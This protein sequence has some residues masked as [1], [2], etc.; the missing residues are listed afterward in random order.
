MSDAQPQPESEAAA[1]PPPAPE[2]PAST[3]E[4]PASGVPPTAPPAPTGG[5]WTRP[6]WAGPRLLYSGLIHAG[7][8]LGAGL[9]IS[10]VVAVLVAVA[11]AA[12]AFSS[13]G[14][15]YSGLVGGSDSG[16]DASA[17]S[18]SSVAFNPLSVF[19]GLFLI[20]GMSLWGHV[21]AKFT[22]D[23]S[24]VH[25]EAHGGV[26][27]VP[28]VVTVALLAA[29]VVWGWL[30][31]RRRPS[32][33]APAR[34][35][36]ALITGAAYAIVLT[37][38]SLAC[39]FYLKVDPVALW[40]TTAGWRLLLGAFVLGTVSAWLGREFA[41][42]GPGGGF[43]AAGRAWLGGVHPL[44]REVTAVAA[45]GTVLFGLAVLVATA[46][47]GA[48]VGY[49]TLL[50]TLPLWF[51][52]AVVFAASLGQLGGI[53]GSS[54][55]SHAET[56]SVFNPGDFA[57]WLW[58]TIV[59][60]VIAA[61]I[62][63]VR[64]GLERPAESRRELRSAWLLPTAIAVL[65][66]ALPWVF[67]APGVS[68]TGIP[69]IGDLHAGVTVAW[70][71]FLTSLVFGA[72]T[73]ATARFAVPVLQASAPRLVAVVGAGRTTAAGGVVPLSRVGRRVVA[74]SA[75]GLGVLCVLAMVGSLV[76]TGVANTLYSPKVVAERY[77][78]D[79]AA[80]HVDA[81][82]A[83]DAGISKAKGVL[84]TEDALKGAKSLLKNPKVTSVSTSGNSAYASVSFTVGGKKETGEVQLK[85]DGTVGLLFPDWKISKPLTTAVI[86]SAPDVSKVTI[87]SVSVDVP[88]SG[89]V[90]VYA[91]PGVYEVDADAGKYFAAPTQELVAGGSSAIVSLEVQPTDALADELN[92]RAKKLLD[93]CAAQHVV[94]P[95][96][97][98]FEEYAFGDTSHVTW[99][100]T[101]Y[102]TFTINADGTFYPDD[103][104]E[105]HVEYTE[106]Y[107]GE[108]EQESDDVSIYLGGKVT[109]D[110]D[111]LTV[112]W[113]SY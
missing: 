106:S 93:G 24:G 100:I 47:A 67:D 43:W 97:C 101:K 103:V 99:K 1:A 61:V 33:G 39:S 110:G 19:T 102:P 72:I 40:L 8:G 26:T 73:E 51:G 27:A 109:V 96:D 87:G 112:E 15:D 28:I 64:I 80:G 3:A 105:A 76:I 56:L 48:H 10:I 11:I 74:G 14:A 2:A 90:D 71:T 53:R 98:P 92:A 38:L 49:A 12:G 42:A 9:V 32:G 13:L 22:A 31:E 4:A 69:V 29:L 34:I 36:A 46:V 41:A 20:F 18:S 83:D 77:L 84:L 91:Y 60:A 85:R 86:V 63:G 7:V 21:S 52:N 75:I 35:A 6:E 55:G 44:V 37:L 23:I 113:E 16:T 95:T 50:P 108:T 107:F 45:S 88:D 17:G 54:T 58:V 5:G 89:Q 66:A 25:I 79:L 111:D 62:A 104:G 30:V 68:I 78:D 82:A 65:W 59:L 81:S 57:P 94:A 70:W